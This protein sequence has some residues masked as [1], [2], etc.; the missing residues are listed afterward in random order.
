MAA[1]CHYRQRGN[2]RAASAALGM[3]TMLAALEPVG[4][5]KECDMGRDLG[6]A[7]GFQVP[8]NG[9]KCENTNA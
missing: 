4:S 6:P 7:S 3:P 9:Y 1:I 5:L 8:I 2:G